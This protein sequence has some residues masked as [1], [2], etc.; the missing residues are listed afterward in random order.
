MTT[1][2]GDVASLLL[3]TPATDR[4]AVAGAY[5]TAWNPATYDCEVRVGGAVTYYNLAALNPTLLSV[6]PVLLA[7][8]SGGPVILGRLFQAAGT[9]GGSPSTPGDGSGGGT[10]PGTGGGGTPST[11]ALSAGPDLTLAHGTTVGIT[12]TVPAGSSGYSWTIMSGPMGT[13]VTITT[14]A[15]LSWVPGSSPTDT[16]DIRQPVCME[17]ALEMCG[18]AENSSTDWTIAYRYIEDIGDDRG[19]TAGVVGF[20]SGTGDM[21]QL[22]QL[23]QTEDPGSPLCAYLDGRLQYCADV[24][25]GSGA[26]SAAASKLGSGFMSAWR[27]EADGNPIFRKV[28]RDMRKSMYWDD[29]LAD[30]VKDGLSPLGLCVYYDVLVNHGQGSDSESYGGIIAAARSGATTPAKGGDEGTYL[31]KVCDLRDKVLRGWGDYQSDGR[32]AAHRALISAGKFALT[33]T[34]S[35]TMYGEAFSFNRPTPPADAVIGQYVL[36]LSA[37]AGGTTT[38]DEVTVTIT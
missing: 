4:P 8:T 13:G 12:P 37:T 10:D 35:W 33:G 14:D 3:S 26:S 5:M 11:G 1:T 36:R 24:G 38:Y 27:S 15:V 30:A 31:T 22:I 34:I 6:G 29:C 16:V 7:Y 25:F 18:T 2:P 23:L 17:M 28:Q 19:Y 32:S 21:L 20:C 9:G